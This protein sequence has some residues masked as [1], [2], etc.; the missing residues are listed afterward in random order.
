[1]VMWTPIRATENR[2]FE[3]FIVGFLTGLFGYLAV[4]ITMLL[5]EAPPVHGPVIFRSHYQ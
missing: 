3:M 5:A 1:M 2:M 4:T